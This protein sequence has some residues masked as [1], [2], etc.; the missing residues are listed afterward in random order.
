MYEQNKILYSHMIRI[1]V[2]SIKVKH[3]N[4]ETII[5]QCATL[6]SLHIAGLM[7]EKYKAQRLVNIIKHTLD[8]INK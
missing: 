7:F 1:L 8:M 5:S 3:K 4:S 2:I 6:Q